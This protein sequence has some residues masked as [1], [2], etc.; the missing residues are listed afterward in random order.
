M[1][2]IKRL[3]KF[4]LNAF[5]CHLSLKDHLRECYCPPDADRFGISVITIFVIFDS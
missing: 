2:V 1:Y 4:S 3:N 5:N